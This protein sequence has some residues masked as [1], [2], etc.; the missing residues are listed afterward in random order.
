MPDTTPTLAGLTAF[1]RG[2]AAIPQT[3]MPDGDPGFADALAFA[4]EWIPQ[5]LL[6]ASATLYTAAV[7]NWSISL[8][9]EFQPDQAG[10]NFFKTLRDA[11]KVNN[12]VPGLVNSASD[13]GT[14]GSITVADATANMS[15][16]DLQRV[17]DPFGR[18]ALSIMQSAGPL[19]GLS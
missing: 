14:A 18:R 2:P 17:K 3:A 9:L 16:E 19:W 10:Q 4:L 8:I 13:N 6:C 15:L 11:Y 7:Y 1:A 12:F 5:W